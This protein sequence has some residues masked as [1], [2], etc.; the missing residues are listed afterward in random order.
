M[1]APEQ[2]RQPLGG[3][4]R[5]DGEKIQPNKKGFPGNGKFSSEFFFVLFLFWLTQKK[6]GL[7]SDKYVS[8]YFGWY[9]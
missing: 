7:L 3:G 8:C 2:A 4:E 1:G 5:R 6:A 9:L